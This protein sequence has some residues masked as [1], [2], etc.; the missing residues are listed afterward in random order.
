MTDVDLLRKHS[1]WLSRLTLLLLGGAILI[2]GIHSFPFWNGTPEPVVR[3]A[4][5]LQLLPS[6][7]YLYAPWA[8]RSG[9]RDFARG[10]LLFPAIAAGCIRAGIAMA[11][12]AT[13]SSVGLPNL[14]RALGDLGM[15]DSQSYRFQG[16]LI[17]DTAYL[18]AGLIGLALVLLG[19]LLSRAAAIQ[20]EA[21]ALRHELEE[22]F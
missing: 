6:A 20:E 2:V 18:A 15:I 21:S 13:L 14:I 19:R 7:F 3:P 5:L 9:F 11:L 12:G 16:Y 4:V 22:F 8:I 10:G 17:F 1:L